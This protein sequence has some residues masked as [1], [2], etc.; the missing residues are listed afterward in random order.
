MDRMGMVRSLERRLF[1]ETGNHG[2]LSRVEIGND[3]AGGL[4]LKAGVGGRH[5]LR[6][7]VGLDPGPVLGSGFR[8]M[9]NS[10]RLTKSQCNPLGD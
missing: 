4:G 7:P 9:R 1:L 2:A 6:H 10:G 8:Q 3:D 5:A